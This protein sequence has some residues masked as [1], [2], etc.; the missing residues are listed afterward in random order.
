[1]HTWASRRRQDGAVRRELA[2]VGYK[3]HAVHFSEMNSVSKPWSL[4]DSLYDIY[5]SVDV[6]YIAALGYKLT[7]P[8]AC[9]TLEL[10]HCHL[11]NTPTQPPRRHGQYILKTKPM[12][13]KK[14]K[15]HTLNQTAKGRPR[16]P[17]YTILSNPLPPRQSRSRQSTCPPTA[18]GTRP[19]AANGFFRVHAAPD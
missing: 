17:S 9:K 16:Y 14:K 13:Q 4:I 1:M 12:Y 11:P 15:T 7:T 8:A 5:A 6:T 19:A 10:A 18:L 2:V 3:P